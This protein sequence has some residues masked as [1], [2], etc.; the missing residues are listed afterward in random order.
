[1]VV[2]EL[3]KIIEK[4]IEFRNE[5]YILIEHVIGLDKT[6]LMCHDVELKA[7]DVDKI[8]KLV[9]KRLKGIPL[10]YLTNVQYFY[11]YK[12]WVNENVLIPRADTEILVEKCIEYYKERKEL[13]ILDMCTGSGCIAIALKKELPF[14][15]VFASDISSKAIE[16]AQKNAELN[17]VSINF[18]LSDLFSNIKYN[19][20]DVIVSNPP[21][22]E[23]L[24]INKLSS[25]VK[26][27]PLIALDGG[28]DGLDFYKKISENAYDYIKKNGKV[29]FEIGYNQADKL[30]EILKYWGFRNIKIYKDY[31]G[32][33]RVVVAEK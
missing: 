19:D 13:K 1:M 27:E 7:D 8:L 33:D 20:F 30:S 21:Y 28:T 15:E 10:Q 6:Y 32:N 22:I 26:K 16:V 12:F 17:N 31:G 25:E 3:I 5:A 11:G 29:Y 14:A 23:T 24:E 2:S 4:E 18:I 9:E